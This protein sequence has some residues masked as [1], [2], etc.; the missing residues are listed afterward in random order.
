MSMP[1]K[2][3]LPLQKVS[4]KKV[5]SA[6]VQETAEI[7]S[8]LDIAQ[9]IAAA[10]QQEEQEKIK[11]ALQSDFQP[12]K[13][14]PPVGKNI[15]IIVGVL[16]GLF[17]L[18]FGGFTAYN[19]LTG[20]G[21]VNIDDLHQENLAGD[22][23]DQQGYVYNGYS[24]VYTDGLWWTEMNKFGTLLKVP[25]H[26]GPRDLADIV[27]QGELDPSFNDGENLYVAIDPDVV[28]KYYT[29]AISELSFNIVKGLDRTPVGSCTK[30]NW[31]CENRTIVSCQNTS[32]KAVIELALANESR[33]DVSGTCIKVQG[34]EYGIVKAVDRLLLQWY[35]VIE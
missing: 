30:E 2:A 7:N 25:L 9:N 15:L 18:S 13:H 22:L 29:L 24:F 19:K 5:K 33:I 34:S 21:V 28:D 10:E 17:V 6:S 26:F 27:P 14:L 12:E 32:G 3:E 35:G 4:L 1:K 31:A 11:K 20:A 23:D 8:T 16:L